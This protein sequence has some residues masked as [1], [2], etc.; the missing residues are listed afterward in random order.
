M[1]EETLT[2]ALCRERA[3]ACRELGSKQADPQKRKEFEDLALAWEQ[4]CDE[5]DRM[6]ERKKAY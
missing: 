1:N 4:L 3:K 2:P 5:I 6:T